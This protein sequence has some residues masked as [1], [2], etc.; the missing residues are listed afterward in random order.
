MDP[1]RIDEGICWRRWRAGKVVRGPLG[2]SRTTPPAMG[3]QTI[4]LSST[5][6]CLENLTVTTNNRGVSVNE[7]SLTT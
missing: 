6:E 5:A 3:Y 4:R 1:G 7:N 2:L